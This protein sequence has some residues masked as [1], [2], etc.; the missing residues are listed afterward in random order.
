VIPLQTD[1]D[2][3]ISASKGRLRQT[4][5]AVRKAQNDQQRRAARDA[6]TL[7]LR[8]VLNRMTCVAAYH[9]LPTEPLDPLF[10]DELALT[11]RVLVPVV[12]GNGPLDW[13]EH[14]GP[15]RRGQYGINE[16]TG[17]RLGSSAIT[18]AAVILVPALAV[19]RAG[20]RLGRGGG[21]YDR[22]LDHL[23]RFDPNRPPTLI[24][25]IYDHELLDAVPSDTHDQPVTAVITPDTG[26]SYCAD[27]HRALP[28]P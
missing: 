4:L 20:H 9:P 8:S 19:D 13:C 11:T 2:E 1:G 7:H 28:A 24:A 18:T 3:P 10:L 15:L 27:G 25:V 26:F 14:P 16:P 5:A 22:T 6:V 12:S 21:H 17:P 23:R